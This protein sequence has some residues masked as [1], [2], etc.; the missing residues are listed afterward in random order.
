M[1]KRLDLLIFE[2]KMV[3]SREKAQRLIMA[4]QVL[5]GS[6][7]LACASRETKSGSK[8]NENIAIEILELPHYVGRGAEKLEGAAKAFKIDFK[9]KVIA[10]IGS[11]T[12]GF[13]DFA[14]QNGAKKVYAIDVG[15]GQLDWRL[16]NDNRVVVME[17]VNARY[18]KDLPEAVNMFLVDVSFISVK[19]ILPVIKNIVHSG[20]TQEHGSNV[21]IGS[22]EGAIVL[23]KPQFEARREI[24]DKCKGVIK[25]PEIHEQLL[26][27]FRKW[28]EEN[29][30]EILGECESPITGD[31]GNKEWFFWLRMK[32]F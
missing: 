21:L 1:K 32:N 29:G 30:L 13:T 25:D 15:K 8:F 24:A 14:L 17:G 5:V 3:D 11:S 26:N 18:L 22:K 9:N 27:D 16:R 28:C 20:S 2:R 23:F 6:K 4:G 12:G 7:K 19:K 10:D 31:K